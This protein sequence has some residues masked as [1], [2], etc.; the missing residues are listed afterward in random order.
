MRNIVDC[1]RKETRPWL[2]KT[3][4]VEAG[5][6]WTYAQLL[7][8][9]DRVAAQLQSHGV[10]PA[11]RVAVVGNDS[12]DFVVAHL[13]VLALGAVAVPMAPA[14]PRHEA[15]SLLLK[16]NI[17]FQLTETTAQDPSVLSE[18]P[19]PGFLRA[20]Y[21]LTHRTALAPDPVPPV[22]AAM[23]PAFIRF[24]S[25]TTGA[26][27]GVLLSHDAIV[28]RTD[29]ANRALEI[30]PQ[31]TVLW[32][33]SMTFHFVVSILLFLR[34]GA[35]IVLC[36]ERFPV[37]VH[38]SLEQGH[39]TFLYASPFH[40][41]VMAASPEF[42]REHMSNIRLAISTAIHLPAPVAESFAAKFGFP[43]AQAY[44]IIEVGLPFVNRSGRLDRASSVGRILPDYDLMIA[45]P[46]AAGT[47][48]IMLR[49]PGMFDAYMAPWR[50]RT[51]LERNGWLAT[52]DLGRIDEEGFLH[53]VARHRDVINF[54]G[55]KIFPQEVEEVLE[56]HPSVAE[57]RVYGEPHPDYGHLPC[58]QI[59]P[60][61][62]APDPVDASEIRR[63]CFRHLAPYKTPK[64]IELTDRLEKTA[65][66]KIRRPPPDG[67]ARRA[68]PSAPARPRSSRQGE[69]AP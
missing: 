21:R 45:H 2:D 47:G 12:A 10:G 44:G 33:L 56:R 18:P 69:P 4:L 30:G 3:A 11:C 14:L 7:E 28:Q 65:S 59:V 49:G 13:A 36:R 31:D 57:A 54:A 32:V 62:T 16:M 29:A 51:E 24:S 40:Y 5:D 26:S 17:H 8:A 53:L 23:N 35:T 68:P 50:T 58:A 20:A 63:F 60:C 42:R 1:I 43:P 41:R 25:G 39:G 61:R 64:R 6:R 34:K 67:E 38:E 22:F 66:D 52:G 55:M 19:V 37:S 9:T 27:K 15:E 46:D 48:E